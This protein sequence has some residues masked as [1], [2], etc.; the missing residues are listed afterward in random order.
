M[1]QVISLI[2]II[3]SI[4][5]FACF[6]S[7][8]HDTLPTRTLLT[9]GDRVQVEVPNTERPSDYP[10]WV[11]PDKWPNATDSGTRLRVD[12][13]ISFPFTVQI[14]F[15]GFEDNSVPTRVCLMYYN[16]SGKW[17]ILKDIRPQNNITSNTGSKTAMFGRYVFSQNYGYKKG[18]I[19]PVIIYV[20]SETSRTHNL[21]QLLNGV[22][23]WDADGVL[24]LG[25]IDN[26]RP[27]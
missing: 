23:K 14:E 1:K 17:T 25:V 4:S 8:P 12:C 24:Y 10:S 6:F 20:E 9:S 26:T 2:F 13:F 19:I 27:R 21:Q 15:T 3:I 5:V 11:K 22:L 16:K 7:D 18:D